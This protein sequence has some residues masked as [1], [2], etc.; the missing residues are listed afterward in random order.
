MYGEIFTFIFTSYFIS[1]SIKC[2]LPIVLCVFVNSHFE[3]TQKFLPCVYFLLILW[4]HRV[5]V[6]TC[7]IFLAVH[8]LLSSCGMQAAGHVGFVIAAHGLSSCDTPA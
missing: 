8:G 4:L 3:S 2:L 6:A 7:G 1:E 5:L